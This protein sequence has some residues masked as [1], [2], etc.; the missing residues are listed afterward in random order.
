LGDLPKFN[1]PTGGQTEQQNAVSGTGYIT[2][3][4]NGNVN[5]I[6]SNSVTGTIPNNT[7]LFANPINHIAYVQWP[8]RIANGQYEDFGANIVAS[9]SDG[10]Y[11]QL[12][13]IYGQGLQWYT[14]G[15]ECSNVMPND[16][17]SQPLERSCL[18]STGFRIDNYNSG[19][20]VNEFKITSSGTLQG[21]LGAYL[22]QTNQSNQFTQS[23]YINGVSA[24]QM[25]NILPYSNNFGVSNWTKNSNIS[26]IVT[27]QADPWGTNT[28]STINV[29]AGQFGLLT[30]YT[31]Y[32]IVAGNTYNVCF[33][34]YSN[35]SGSYAYVNVA[36]GGSGAVAL[37]PMAYPT[38]PQCLTVTAGAST[39]IATDFGIEVNGSLAQSITVAG[40]WVVP[41]GIG[42]GYHPTGPTADLSPVTAV[43]VGSGNGAGTVGPS[44]AY[45]ALLSGTAGTAQCSESVQGVL[46]IANCLLTGY[47]ETGTA[48]TFT[49]P[50]A[51]SF[52]PVLQEGAGSC[53]TYNPTTTAT[54]LT[55]PANAAMTAESCNVVLLGQ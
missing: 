34:A 11:K 31:T 28:A 49:F 29:A 17:T 38:S 4:A 24:G 36:N 48:Q 45:Y 35:V 51:F 15:G 9:P 16:G 5:L 6:S 33:L 41:L 44:N 42:T 19:S 50:T 32:P 1:V 40:I 25:Q 8:G 47:Q 12:T 27:G 52:V 10:Y 22:A 39:T 3:Y 53:G 23:Q 37:L 21:A 13:F 43:V 14:L 55:L 26:S 30:G 18:D 2:V 20:W 46:K 54:A 7:F